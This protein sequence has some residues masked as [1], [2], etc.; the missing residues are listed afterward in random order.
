MRVKLAVSKCMRDRLFCYAAQRTFVCLRDWLYSVL[1]FDFPPECCI[2]KVTQARRVLAVAEFRPD[3][4][5]LA[6]CDL[7]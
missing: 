2:H 7:G 4:F 6:V 3:I 1:H 5:G